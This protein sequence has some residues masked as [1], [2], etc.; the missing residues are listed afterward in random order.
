VLSVLSRMVA[1][2]E[3]PGQT[4]APEPNRTTISTKAAYVNSSKTLKIMYRAKQR[5]P[6]AFHYDS[7]NA[8]TVTSKRSNRTVYLF[9]C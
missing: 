3:D 8:H 1:I 4:P 2:T 9:L 6:A 7:I 5:M